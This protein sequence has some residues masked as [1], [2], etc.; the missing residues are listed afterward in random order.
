MPSGAAA[1]DPITPFD[2]AQFLL[3]R[4]AIDAA[5]AAEVRRAC[6]GERVPIGQLLMQSGML[7]VRQIMH[8][9]EL[10][11]DAPTEKFGQLAVRCGYISMRQLEDGLGMQQRTRR[12]AIEVVSRMGL[13]RP[14]QLVELSGAYVALLELTL[15]T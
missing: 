3:D 7:S 14:D 4:E 9:L 11:A 1:R 12:H 2:F 13:L 15:A 6:E 10:Q 5:Q 8:V